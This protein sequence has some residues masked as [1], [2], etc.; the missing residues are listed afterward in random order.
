MAVKE[1]AAIELT[2]T[3]ALIRTELAR[4]GGRIVFDKENV[5]ISLDVSRPVNTSE[6]YALQVTLQIEGVEMLAL[7]PLRL[8]NKLLEE[9]D[10]PLKLKGLP[11]LVVE[12][13][14]GSAIDGLRE[15][16][17][18]EFG[19]GVSITD[20]TLMSDV[21]VTE[22]YVDC[23]L[24]WGGENFR[25]CFCLGD[26]TLDSV[27]EWVRN[28]PSKSILS[29]DELGAVDSKVSIAIDDQLV[30]ANDVHSLENGDI[31]LF[32]SPWP[33]Q[34]CRARL[35]VGDRV[36]FGGVLAAAESSGVLKFHIGN[37]ENVKM[38]SSNSSDDMWVSGPGSQIPVNVKL[39]VGQ[40]EMPMSELA[41]LNSGSVIDLEGTLDEP[42]SVYANGLK[43]GM[44]ELVSV[45]GRLGARI[46]RVVK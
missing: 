19:A 28:L 45:D 18:N 27:L 30:A 37:W 29:A 24:S 5:S 9:R 41:K 1:L 17:A 23:T 14:L 26:A 42:V 12:V 21:T 3:R 10:F 16:V 46:T 7:L 13:M 33:Q 44:A 22:D 15:S 38:D 6:V 4:I 40:F 20:Y 25:V 36:L 32:D 31:V 34:E 2:K 39:V 8:I 35:W 11:P 43:V